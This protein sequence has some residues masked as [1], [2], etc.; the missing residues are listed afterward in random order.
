VGACTDAHGGWQTQ[1]VRGDRRWDETWHRLREW[2]ESRGRSERLAAQILLDQGFTDLDPSHP[3][4]GKDGTADALARRDGKRWVLAAYFPRGQQ[5]SKD[6]K[7][8]FLDD[9]R[10]V[11]ANKADA[12]AFVTNQELRRA[13]RRDLERGVGC[14]VEIFHLERVVAVLDQPRMHGVR[15]QFLGIDAPDGA[16]DRQQRLDELWRASIARCAARWTGVGLPP[17]EARALAEDQSVGA[18]DASLYPSAAEPLV[19]WTAPMGSGKSIAAE[20]H[21]QVCVE[22]A[23]AEESA[24]VPV[25]LRASE[26]CP[27]LRAAVEAAAQEVGAVRTAGARVVVDGIDELGH[28]AG[29]ELLMHARV[30]VGTWPSTT[31]LMTSRGVPV[32][33]EAPE[34]KPFRPLTESEQQDC[35]E[36]G[37]GGRGATVNLHSLAQPV[38]ATMRQPMFALLVGVWMRERGGA[39]RAPVDMLA[40]LG[41]RATRDLRVDQVHLRALAVRSVARELGPVAAGDVLEGA[42]DDELLATGMLERRS[43]GLAFV[44]PA[45]A[46]WFAAQ[47]LLLAELSAEQLVAAPEDLELWRYPLALAISLGS[48]RRARE[49]LGQLLEVEAGFALRV[50]DAT[51]GQAVLGGAPAPPW[52]E[53]GER[54]REALQAL[55]D[56]IG[57]LA[58]LVCDVD[59]GGRVRPLA[60]SSAP[61]HLTVAFWRGTEQ[62]PDVFPMPADVHPFAPGPDWGTLR[63]GPVGP[64]AAWAWHWASKG[65]HDALD[66]VLQ[67]RRLPVP[68][69]GPLAYEAAWAAACDLVEQSVLLTASLELSRLIDALHGVPAEIYEQGPVLFRRGGAIHDLR[70][71]RL[72][73]SRAQARGETHLVASVPPADNTHGGGGWIGE[74]YSDEHLVNVATRIYEAAIVGYRQLVERWMPTLL[75][76]LEHHVLMPM[77]V[78]GFVASGRR[79]EPPGMVIPQL[80]G[81]I[82]ALPPGAGDE[83]SMQL[84][85]KTSDFS[86][87]G[88]SYAQQR[89][90]RPEASR[91]I[92]GTHGGMP[93]EVG[94]RY[95]ISDVVYSWIARDLKRLGLVGSLAYSRSGGAVVSFDI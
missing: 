38:R 28:Q 92:T 94:Q 77:R 26:C 69:D 17:H 73:I 19:V 5:T 89:A 3:L 88:S 44:L 46:Q 12:F 15:G 36:I 27:S 95:P 29:A 11:E 71:L 57:P 79:Q 68:P 50:L 81:Y 9:L 55:A 82:E 76:Q 35:V 45:V 48:A 43:G 83:V 72:T 66:R 80:T 65:I 30:L 37:A 64:G 47:A 59:A 22:A 53:G 58:L 70:G 34:N 16:L 84:G 41:K 23:A 75:S 39:P 14:P 51:F 67:A 33:L 18:V 13:E 87:G 6:L 52:R 90:A 10:G 24:P 7:D 40:M 86:V 61:H 54:V 31:V 32:L 74:F 93:F 21:H 2:T 62:R 78:V 56:A 8:K 49:L 85:D 1:C 91:W 25:F 20:R 63:S 4:G 60:V 42:R